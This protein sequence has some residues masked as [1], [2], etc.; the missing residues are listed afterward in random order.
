M[1]KGSYATHRMRDALTM[2]AHH[3]SRARVR[4]QKDIDLSLGTEAEP[5]SKNS[6]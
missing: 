5:K 2:T 1:V 6:F 3:F 4:I